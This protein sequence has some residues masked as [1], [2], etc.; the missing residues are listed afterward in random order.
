M[1]NVQPACFVETDHHDDTDL[2]NARKQY[3]KIMECALKTM[4]TI[5]NEKGNCI[6]GFVKVLRRIT[7]IR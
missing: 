3:R 5:R 2:H 6:G 7:P 1:K 4:K